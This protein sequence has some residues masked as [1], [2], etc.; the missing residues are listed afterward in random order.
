MTLLY[1]ILT[2][3]HNK[4]ADPDTVGI[5]LVEQAAQPAQTSST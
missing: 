4:K 5:G 3:G 1:Q 2:L